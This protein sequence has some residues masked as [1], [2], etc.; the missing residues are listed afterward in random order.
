MCGWPVHR[1]K[2]S[3]SRRALSDRVAGSSVYVTWEDQRA[4][5]Y[6]APGD[7]YFNRSMDGGATWLSSDVRL[8]T[9]PP[10]AAISRHAQIAASG[11]SVYVTWEDKRNS[12]YYGGDI[13]CNRS[14]DGGTTWLGSDVRLNT[15]PAGAALATWPQIAASGSS[16][17][18]TW[19]DSRSGSVRD[20]YFNIPLG[21]QPYGPATPGSGG[22]APT[23]SGDGTATIG[24]T[25]SIDVTNGLGSATGAV[26]V[27][28]GPSS[29]VSIPVLGGTVLVQPT[30]AVPLMLGGTAGVP[31]AGFGFLPISIPANRSLVGTNLNF[32]GVFLDNGAPQGISM[33]NGVET[34]IG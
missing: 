9:D 23:L 31:G 34:W 29:K 26:F 21:H 30:L 2:R 11:S 8:N 3:L 7:V 25:P 14:V 33:S 5:G 19:S 6:Y 18:V 4:G 27:G 15:N 12:S 17:Y 13:Y 20:I 10:G 1:R 16:A 32:Q 28:A 24:S 22:L